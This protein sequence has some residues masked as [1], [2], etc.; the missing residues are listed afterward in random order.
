MKKVLISGVA[1][2]FGKYMAEEFSKNRYKVAGFDKVISD[3]LDI[4]LSKILSQYKCIDLSKIISIKDNFPQ[5]IRDFNPDI[6]VNNAAMKYFS[7]FT[8]TTIDDIESVITVNFITPLILTKYWLETHNP[9]KK[10]INIVISSNAGYKGYKKGALYCSSKG[11]LRIFTEAIN[12]E[13]IKGLTTITIC[14]E[15]FSTKPSIKSNLSMQ[16]VFNEL[17]KAINRNVSSELPIISTKSK[18]QYIYSDLKK[19]F[20]RSH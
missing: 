8:K 20:M 17:L 11:G 1:E 16:Y 19:F 4:K 5:L 10:R 6:L 2:G 15:T 13:N 7:E 18:L 9:N 14:P 3:D 12:D